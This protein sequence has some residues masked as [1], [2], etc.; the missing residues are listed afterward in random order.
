MKRYPP[1]LILLTLLI[2]GC[3]SKQDNSYSGPRFIDAGSMGGAGLP[4]AFSMSAM[5]SSTSSE[6]MDTN[7]SNRYEQRAQPPQPVMSKQ[8]QSVY[9][10]TQVGKKTISVTVE[11]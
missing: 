7:R 1:A 4:S 11:E 8:L 6:G 5:Q 3:S 2:A 10:A 9:Q